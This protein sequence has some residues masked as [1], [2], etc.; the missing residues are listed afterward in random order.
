MRVVGLVSGGKD[1]IWNLHYCHHFDH[2][3]V[4]LA[5]LAP[6]AGTDELDSYMY[7]TVGSNVNAFIARALE[8]PLIQRVITG[9]PKG[10]DAIDYSPAE[11]DEVEDLFLLLQDVLEQH[12]EIDAVSCGA[13]LSNYQRL[14]VE[15]VCSRLGLKVLAFMWRQEQDLLL[16]QMISAGLDARIVKVASMGLDGKHVGK[17]I[18]DD[19]FARYLFGLGAKWG[20][21][22]CGEGGEYETIA[23]DAPL[24]QSALQISSMETLSDCASSD[25]FYL[26]A[27]AVD[28]EPKPGSGA[29]QL[30]RRVLA[31]YSSLA[32][33]QH[34][35]P[36]LCP[37][38][39]D[40]TL[41]VA[42]SD[43]GDGDSA[44]VA[45]AGDVPPT[46]GLGATLVQVGPLW[47]SSSLDAKVCGVALGGSPTEQ[48]QDLLDAVSAWLGSSYALSLSDA[49]FVELQVRDL[50]RFEEINCVY[51]KYFDVNPPP[52]VC[53]QTSLPDGLHLRMRMLVGARRISEAGPYRDNSLRVQSIST[54][55]MACIGPYS[56]AK[57]VGQR[58]LLSAGVL[59]LV[60]HSMTLPSPGAAAK[61]WNTASQEM[62]EDCSSDHS[63]DGEDEEAGDM[64][65]HQACGGSGRM[66]LTPE[67]TIA[68]PEQW[69]AEL[70]LL[71][72][73]LRNVLA[74]MGAS[75]AS[76]GWANI[77]VSPGC[78]LAQVQHRVQ[79]YMLR[80]GLPEASLEPLVTCCAVPRLPKGG[81]VEVN[82]VYVAD[83]GTSADDPLGTEHTVTTAQAGQVPGSVS[84]SCRCLADNITLCVSDFVITPDSAC[85]SNRSL[86]S[87]S[88]EDVAFMI[89][90]CFGALMGASATT[91]RTRLGNGSC[92]QVL[93]ALEG[94][95]ADDA[96]VCAVQEI[97]RSAD[98]EEV[99]VAS[100]MPVE[101]LSH[102]A[103]L[104]LV[105]MTS[106]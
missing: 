83:P 66:S 68:V 76:I 35:F 49:D 59:G 44:R 52:R 82:V 1:S 50:S 97:L 56:Q 53:I 62:G 60:P 6:P 63:D 34:T 14:R 4:C 64:P 77:L 55:A 26:R 70:W 20:V 48:C 17:S 57:W 72:R 67:G 28:V 21:H 37:V 61:A 95:T 42:G 40:A 71:M 25:V 38:L 11:G 99:C 46:R 102:G 8:L 24:Y 89:Q 93:Y 51:A 39:P 87:A 105:V 41:D 79:A 5:H 84:T 96:V 88:G 22:V 29:S 75:F 85:Q 31:A 92:V 23:V 36:V 9:R 98:L 74:V 18:L 30:H 10:V 7:Q 12:P 91:A 3:L 32:Y 27:Q 13:I 100:F 45:M 43:G 15:N 94:E 47:A 80:D 65:A 78:D 101:A 33:Y 86:P 73:S 106:S 58:L 16:R 2:E 81:A 69:E 19:A 90:E 103:C 104:R 54:W